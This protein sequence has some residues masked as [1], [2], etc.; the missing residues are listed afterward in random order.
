MASFRQ[1]V[2]PG[3][4]LRKYLHGIPSTEKGSFR[5]VC[6]FELTSDQARHVTDL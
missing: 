3:T 1:S 4:R 6:E 5:D 2:L